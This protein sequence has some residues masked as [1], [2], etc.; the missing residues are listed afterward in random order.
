[1]TS[2]VLVLMLMFLVT[3]E[4]IGRRLFGTP[5]SGQVETATLSLTVIV[6]LG[7]AYTQ[8]K[9][10]HI[11]VEIFINRFRGRLRAALEAACLSLSI[12]PVIMMSL[13][14]A[15]K[16]YQ[17]FVG[18]EFIAGGVNFPVWPGRCAVAFGLALLSITLTVQIVNQLSLALMGKGKDRK[19]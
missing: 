1:M 5:I 3:A 15:E 11:R 9:D 16:A 7:L 2:E 12:V 4:I 10:S 17:S 13:A 6:Y 18:G 14:T 19:A 8:F